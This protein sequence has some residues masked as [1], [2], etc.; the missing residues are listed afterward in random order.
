[1]KYNIPPLPLPF[2]VETKVVLKQLAKST[3]ALAELKGV[4]ATIPNV[5]IL[6]NTLVLQEAKDSS[7][8]ENII[9]TH[10]ELYKAELNIAQFQTV[11]TKE[12][13]RYATA[14]KS[15]FEEVRK[16][17]IINHSTIKKIQA[18]LEK[19]D[20][21]YRRVAGT[22]LENDLTKEVVYV[23]PQTHNQIVNCM[24]VL[25]A[26]INDDTLSDVD[27]L[28]KMAIIHHQF[29]S[30][31][32]FYDGNGRTG[33]ILNI[34]Y[35]ILKDVLDLPTLYLSRYIINNKAKYYRLLQNVRDKGNWETW[36]LFILKGCQEIAIESITLIKNIKNI[37]QQMKHYIRENYR[38]YSQDLLNNLFRH[39]YTKI[40][41]LEHE[42]RMNR[43]TAAKY[44]NILAAD[45]NLEITKIKIGKSNYY[46]ND[47]LI[48]LLINHKIEV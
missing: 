29:E 45:E 25:I 26:Y 21:G 3:A 16:N 22:K 35:L 34:L 14:L 32:P 5:S 36:I 12:V 4:A 37:M 6:L 20:A 27:P 39:P 18:I 44:L 38:F 33:R 24:D 7:E 46:M 28:I 42:L 48:Q 2:E 43:K 40:D 11:A 10:D 23:P 15:A 8:V 1:M 41:F 31:H 30:I 9:T 47:A 13:Q 17:K 19:N